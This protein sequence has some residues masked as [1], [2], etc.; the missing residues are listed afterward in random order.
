MNYLYNFINGTLTS[1][2]N[3][4]DVSLDYPINIRFIDFNKY[5]DISDINIDISNKNFTL[6][7]GKDN[8]DI[9]FSNPS[10]SI[11]NSFDLSY[12]INYKIRKK[13]KIK[14][15]CRRKRT[16]NLFYSWSN[17]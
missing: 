2:N 9:S 10:F 8:E 16:R 6:H 4:Y 3:K 13:Y 17:I 15:F 12:T 14:N 5:I 1:S 7:R 11:D